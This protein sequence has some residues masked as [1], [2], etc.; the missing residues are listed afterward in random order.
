MNPKNF[1]SVLIADAAEVA[2]SRGP[3]E[4][5]TSDLI[6]QAFAGAITKA[7]FAAKDVGGLG[8]ASCTQL[9]D[10]AIDLP[11]RLSIS[12]RWCTDD[13]HCGAGAIN[14]LQHA[15]RPIQSGDATVI[16]LM[17]GDR[18]APEDF[19]RLVDFDRTTAPSVRP[20]PNGGP[21]SLFAMLTQRHAAHDGFKRPDSAAQRTWAEQNQHAVY[22]TPMQIDDYLA[23]PLVADPLG[24]FDC[25]PVVP[26]N[27]IVLA[28][29][30]CVRLAANVKV[31][32]LQSLYNFD[33]PQEDGCGMVQY[34]YGMC[35]NAVVMAR[36]DQGGV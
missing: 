34:S 26:P 4:W 35:A 13:C 1:D 16:V 25:V 9:R 18:C 33:H 24:R 30:E 15:L 8:G 11:W 22:R 10:H 12:P 29:V 17:S 31:R 20:L 6:T 21:N 32:A 14:L 7:G 19:S 5:E 28:R 36:S 2:Y 3:Y 23:A 27:A